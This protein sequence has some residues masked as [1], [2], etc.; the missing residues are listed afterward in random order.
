MAI[1]KTLY[2][3]AEPP[4]GFPVKPKDGRAFRRGEVISVPPEARDHPWFKGHDGKGFVRVNEDTEVGIDISKENVDDIEDFVRD[5]NS[6]DQLL[7]WQRQE[8]GNKSRKTA[9]SAIENRISDLIGASVR[10]KSTAGE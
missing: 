7:A 6:V 2:N 5:C 4:E 8:L 9:L 3:Y 1:F 10:D